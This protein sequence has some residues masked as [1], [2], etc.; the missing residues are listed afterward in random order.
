[1]EEATA[2]KNARPV[3]ATVREFVTA[4]LRPAPPGSLAWCTFFRE[5][6]KADD[7]L[8][9]GKG[10][11][12]DTLPDINGVN[13]Y[14]RISAYPAD[15]A[16]GKIK[17][18]L[19]AGVVL[20][21][22]PT[23]KGK[24]ELVLR[25]LGPPSYKIKTSESE[26]WG[27]LSQRL[28]TFDEIK[29][30]HDALVALGMCDKSGNNLVRYGRL[31]AGI[32]N[33]KE[34]SK[35]YTVGFIE[36]HLEQRF[37]LE[38]FAALIAHAQTLPA[39]GKK[40]RETDDELRALILSGESL[41]DPLMKLAL[42]LL[43]QGQLEDDTEAILVGL[44]MRSKDRGSPRWKE[45]LEEIPR[46]IKTA[47][48]KLAEKGFKV[49]AEPWPEP[50][51][52]FAELGCVPFQPTDLPPQLA[53]YPQLYAEQMGFDPSLTLTAAVVAA[54]AAINDR[55]Q[56]L[57]DPDDKAWFQSARLWLLVIAYI[58][59]GK[60]PAHKE[61]I[62]PL[63]DKDQELHD[64][65]E[66]ECA[67]LA[68][69]DEKK[70]PPHPCVVVS[71]ATAQALRDTLAGNERGVLVANDEFHSFMGGMDRYKSGGI[72]GHD[73]AEW[74]KAYDGGP[75]N[76]HL[77]SKG[78]AVRVPNWSVSILTATT[79]DG[80][81]KLSKHLPEDG[82]L[83]RFLAVQAQDRTIPELGSVAH[84]QLSEA[85]EHYGTLLWRLWDLLPAVVHLSPQARVRFHAWRKQNL[86]LQK[87]F[88]SLDSALEGH[89]AKYDNMLLRVALTYH[90]VEVVCKEHKEAWVANIDQ[91]SVATLETAIRFL[92]RESHHAIAIYLGRSGSSTAYGLAKEV[93]RMIVARSE[94]ENVAG[95]Q[96]REV[97]RRVRDFARAEGYEQ[98]N[99][100][101][102]LVDNGWLRDLDPDV[103]GGYRKDHP[104]RY[105]VNPQLAV[106]FA[107]L[108][109]L[110]R[111][112]R[113]LV[114]QKIQ[115][116]AAARRAGA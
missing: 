69:D 110:E 95:L 28:L 24:G 58:G 49:V 115:A 76:V 57:V 84:A 19:G 1:M 34:Y 107:E 77:V 31:P 105:A 46:D 78:G 98:I 74:I 63:W 48:A 101:K 80:L 67:A 27:Y 92:D 116:S 60:S 83:H 66:S 8:W 15:A 4:L 82:L 44:M 6:P 29:P 22:D 12:P 87:A 9:R 47:A 45:R 108:A 61:M 79:P 54:A 62:Q 36:A 18:A 90:C 50:V 17:A 94:Q 11:T 2:A 114:M 33:K 112:R 64:D 73:R 39:A 20:L 41:H 35:P 71:G 42:R 106:A 16:S 38:H 88:R 37:P 55:V 21:D 56:V 97:L 109:Q 93:A 30:I 81:Q 85:R 51:N 59:A 32:N 14:Y 23:T 10:Y 65:W 40:K 68:E 91:I 52:I 86:E 100:M 96:W 43:R 5:P 103:A 3:A 13:A 102:L 7:R 99:V 104:T 53:A 113:A 72:G 89:A 111:T 75:R 26:Q 70:K 25:L